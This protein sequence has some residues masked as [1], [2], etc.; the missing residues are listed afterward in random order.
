VDYFK[1]T[2]GDDVVAIHVVEDV[3]K[4]SQLQ[5]RKTQVLLKVK[6]YYLN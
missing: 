4:Y 1:D 5:D 2:F 3:G 6:H